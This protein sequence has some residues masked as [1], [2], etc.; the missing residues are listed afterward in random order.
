[1][2]PLLLLLV[3]LPLAAQVTSV[4]AQ[5]QLC[6]NGDIDVC[7]AL[8]LMRELKAQAPTPAGKPKDT[9]AQPANGSTSGGNFYAGGIS[10]LPQSSPKP[11]VW[12][13]M[14]LQTS[15]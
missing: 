6:A 5:E 3:A 9:P 7:K 15:K 14:A 10:I 1:M 11:S 8:V 4:A 13:A 2:K 12:G